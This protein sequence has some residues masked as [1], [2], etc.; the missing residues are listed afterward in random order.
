M[1]TE[2]SIAD[3]RFYVTYEDGCWRAG[4]R[5]GT[6]QTRRRRSTTGALSDLLRMLLDPHCEW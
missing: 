5:N 3:G 4:L 2:Y 1:D 6:L